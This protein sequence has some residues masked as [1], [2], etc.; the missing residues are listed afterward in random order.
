MAPKSRPQSEAVVRPPTILSPTILI[1]D[2]AQLTGT[3]PIRV[4]NHTAIHPRCRLNSTAGPITIGDYCILN[5]RTQIIA[6]DGGLVFE[7]YVVL[8]T[9]AV[10]EARRV[11]EGS[12]IEVGA[13]IGKGAEVGKVLF[14]WSLHLLGGVAYTEG[15][16]LQNH[17]A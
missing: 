9:N 4:G 5:E 14:V 12:V 3:H 17:A 11:G 7:D 8:E 16:E 2:V 6:P 10:V 13:K 15:P 1:S